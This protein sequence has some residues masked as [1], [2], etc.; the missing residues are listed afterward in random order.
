MFKWIKNIDK[1]EL[2]K[3]TMIVAGTVIAVVAVAVTVKAILD[4]N[5]I[6]SPVSSSGNAVDKLIFLEDGNVYSV[7]DIDLFSDVISSDMLGNV[8]AY[9]SDFGDVLGYGLLEPYEW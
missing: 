5:S 3:K 2:K 4:N 9:A 8:V 7:V 1:K 6:P